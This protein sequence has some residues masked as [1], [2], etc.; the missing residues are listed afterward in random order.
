MRDWAKP[1]YNSKAWKKCRESYIKKRM[2][3]DG[4]ICE[5]CGIEQGYIVHHIQPLTEQNVSNPFIC[6]NH[7]NLRYECKQCHDR[8]EGHYLDGK[9]MRQKGLVCLFDRETGQIVKDLRKGL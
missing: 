9:G 6:L 7:D 4:G 2:Q 8:E 1:F 3:I 5:V